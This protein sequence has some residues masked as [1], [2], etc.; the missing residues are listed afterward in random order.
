MAGIGFELKNFSTGVDCLRHFGLTD[1]LE[2]YVPDQ[3]SWE[4][5]FFLGLCFCV[6]SQAVQDTAENCWYV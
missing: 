4:L 1:M 6:I 2:L 5:C 3:C